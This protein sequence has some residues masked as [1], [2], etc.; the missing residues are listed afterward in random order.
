MSEASA[1]KS[2]FMLLLVSAVFTA[3][4]S[5]VSAASIPYNSTSQWNS[6]AFQ[7]TTLKGSDLILDY[8]SGTAR[9]VDTS[10][11]SSVEGNTGSGEYITNVDINGISQSS[12][13]NNGYADFT[14]ST[15]NAFVPGQSYTIDVTLN[16]GGLEDYIS[17]AFDWNGNRDL[18]DDPV[19]RID[20]CSGNPCQVS[21][22]IEVP[23]TISPNKSV[24]MRVMGGW[25]EYH[26]SPTQ[27]T[28]FNEIEDYSAYLP[29]YRSSGSY[30]TEW[31][32]TNRLASWHNITY[33]S[34][35]GSETDGQLQ[36]SVSEDGSEVAASD[37]FLLQDGNNTIDISNLQGVPYI[38]LE[39]SLSTSDVRETPL[40]ESMN[41]NHK[42]INITRTE[43]SDFPETHRFNLSAVAEHP[44]GSKSIK[45]CKLY[46][47]ASYKSSFRK[48]ADDAE[49]AELK[50]SS[51]NSSKACNATISE[52]LLN[53]EMGDPV[54]ETVDYYFEFLDGEVSRVTEVK[55]HSLPNRKPSIKST[56]LEASS[57]SQSFNFSAVGYDID[58]GSSEI[59][60][61]T[62]YAEDQEGN[63]FS[64]GTLNTNGGSVDEAW[65]N[66]TVTSATEGLTP[67]EPLDIWAEFTDVGDKSASSAKTS[68]ELPNH[69]P[70]VESVNTFPDDSGHSFDISAVFSDVDGEDDLVNGACRVY[71]D[72]GEQKIGISSSSTDIYNEGSGDSK[73]SCNYTVDES[74]ANSF[75]VGEEIEVKVEFTD[76]W[77]GTVNSSAVRE[78]IPNNEPDRTEGLN[79]EVDD[80]S[81]IVEHIF[82]ISF[83]NPEDP[84][85][86]GVSINAYVGSSSDPS[87]V[88]NSVSF[89]SGEYGNENILEIGNSTQLLDGEKYF[90]E[91]ESCDE[92]GL[93]N[94]TREKTSFTMNEEPL[95]ENAGSSKD[96]SI[97]TD[98]DETTISANITDGQS[99]VQW[100]VLEVRN[101]TGGNWE[102][103]NNKSLGE[104]SGDFWNTS[105]FKVVNNTNY[106]WTVTAS[107]GL[108]TSSTSGSFGT[109]ETPPIIENLSLK[110]IEGEHSFTVNANI[111]DA[112]GATTID[113]AAL[114]ITDGNGNRLEITPK[115]VNVS[116]DEAS[117]KETVVNNSISGFEVG[118]VLDVELKLTTVNGTTMTD[119]GSKMIPNRP[120]KVSDIEIAPSNAETDQILNI[121][122]NL[123]DPEGDDI[124]SSGRGYQW[125][126]GGTP[127]PITDRTVPR[128]STEEGQTWNVSV[129]VQDE[130]GAASATRY[131]E[132]KVTI[133]NSIPEISRPL[134]TE[135]LG[136]HNFEASAAALDP[137]GQEDFKSCSFTAKQDSNS[138]TFTDPEN[139]TTYGSSNEMLCSAKIG[140]SNASW[141]E[142]TEDVNISF[143]FSDEAGS[144]PVEIS[145]TVPNQIPE[146]SLVSPLDSNLSSSSVTFE[147]NM[148]DAEGDSLSADLRVFDESGEAF[149]TA[150]LSSTSETTTL[151]DSRYTWN[152]TV[153]DSFDSKS[154]S[155]NTSLSGSFI[156]DTTPPAVQEL[157]ATSPDEPYSR[158]E[159]NDS[160]R[161]SSKWSDNFKLGEAK[162][163]E[164][165]TNSNHSISPEDF[166]NG[167]AN[168]TLNASQV[169]AGEISYTVYA[170]DHL[171]NQKTVEDT[172][173]IH[174]IEKPSIG[175]VSFNPELG[176]QSGLD[177][178]NSIDVEASITDNLKISDAQI[179]YKLDDSSTWS[180]S[181]LTRTNGNYSG[182]FMPEK[183]GIYV[184]QVSAEDS[185]G[186][187]VAENFTEE[188]KI[189]L[190]WSTVDKI[191]G[192]STFSNNLVDFSPFKIENTGDRNLDFN[193]SISKDSNLTLE[194][195][196]SDNF[197]L[198]AGESLF[199]DFNAS[200][201]IENQTTAELD[202]SIE[203]NASNGTETGK[204][205]VKT[206][207]GTANFVEGPF[208]NISEGGIFPDE[209]VQ[210]SSVSLRVSLTNIG[211]EA[212]NASTVSYDLPPGWKETLGGGN[213]SEIPENETE[214]STL[215][216]DISP[217]AATGKQSIGVTV[218][219]DNFSFSNSFP[220]QVNKAEEEETEETPASGGGGFSPPVGSG[221]DERIPEGTSDKILKSSSSF[222]LVRGED[223]NF[224]I[225]FTNPTSYNLSNITVEASGFR[226]QYL[227]LDTESIRSLKVNESR[228][229]SVGITA[230]D[231]FASRSF[232]LEFTISGKGY[233]PTAFANPYFNFTLNKVVNLEIHEISESR[234]EN[235]SERMRE[236]MEQMKNEGLPAR[237]VEE[238]LSESQDS[239]EE[240]RYGEVQQRFQTVETLFSTGK[241]VQDDL[242]TLRN[243]VEAAQSQGL[244]V[245]QSRRMMNLAEAAL[246]RGAYQT[247]SNRVD[248]AQNLYQLETKG[249][250]NYVY[251]ITSNWMKVLSLIVVLWISSLLGYY[252]LRLYRINS[253]LEELEDREENIA[254]MKVQDQKEAFEQQSM[255]LDEYEDA[256]ENYNQELIEMI[257][258]RAELESQKANITNLKEEKA[259]KQERDKLKE[260]IKES[261]EDYVRGNIADTGMYE[262]K[263]E[264][265][266]EKLST[267]ESELAEK[268]AKSKKNKSKLQLKEPGK[269]LEKLKQRF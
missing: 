96:P 44:N 16:T 88:E 163:Y 218:K 196:I 167:W 238:I 15:S 101:V 193:L 52:S 77:N 146:V 207:S 63:Q 222:E 145:K 95:I 82:N 253:R 98:G 177:P 29:G 34:N 184:F 232:E 35:L 223:Q 194:K 176:N 69:A 129:Q 68:G 46:Y 180:S 134:E 66:A 32:D 201:S 57:S 155:S 173:D 269:W 94:D 105:S 93:C 265:L 133:E 144:K 111:S 119:S 221:G 106:E 151:T 188:V 268:E 61:C 6:G 216:A 240:G 212:L 239:I 171:G 60:S 8:R 153:T 27:D 123:S 200:T 197:T 166:Q 30:S 48:L 209:V 127:I 227:D 4:I 191:S 208:I 236:I 1:A 147:W 13:D 124:P 22:S 20:H 56:S 122:Y 3:L 108:E 85:G 89:G 67:E 25:D 42:L 242:S 5:P 164:N 261:Q 187:R 74:L 267:V 182:S 162:I 140:P 54:T 131:A 157:S 103:R 33:R 190:T 107:D 40:L 18:S 181:S 266:T 139:D 225:N 189:D 19:Y 217:S 228:P 263:V 53:L 84:D 183:E 10:K 117:I 230:P 109:G 203:V 130:Y 43:T 64:G 243:K 50:N 246:N 262:T 185:Y 86:D 174:D 205:P 202:F 248:E 170:F 215:S 78:S 142:P 76:E 168:V 80:S 249:E 9:D 37:T 213:I 79:P 141:I 175:E 36:V 55:N 51:G 100:A 255:S 235:Y 148:D 136:N 138:K 71:L 135:N 73:A 125:I 206:V 172:V 247:A 38:K 259:L 58:D 11:Y 128:A 233:D 251:L 47:K 137:N 152:V 115:I 91:L 254:E 99:N 204:D 72:D 260:I 149:S 199:A 159:Q 245:D 28:N 70:E 220:I 31:I 210:D 114:N 17:V 158:V 39:P 229:I 195:D 116:G 121:T 250:V 104:Q 244:S 21:G 237:E 150:D 110:D 219:S 257:E 41:V 14:N 65:C 12:G 126:R 156:V 90:L 211:L 178:N 179:R 165:I 264:E 59:Q 118:E 49:A 252:R 234:A 81:Q 97:L 231:F 45:N 258:E 87:F 2:G 186:N 226:S 23:E 7:D 169:E 224:T 241:E 192:I 113:E 161:I 154:L 256:V 92:Y 198:A 143:S 26:T 112:D 75:S 132:Q 62:V 214:T 160:L 83:T 24:V 120:P 102:L